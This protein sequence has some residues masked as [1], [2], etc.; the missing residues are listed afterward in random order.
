MATQALAINGAKVYIVGRTGEKPET[1][2]RTH[3]QGIAGKIIP[4]AADIT[5]KSAI[6]KL[7]KEI[8]SQEKCQFKVSN[9][10]RKLE[11]SVTG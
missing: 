6:T 11:F 4:I 7:V 5:S 3:G 9:R 1:V 2:V 10:S 8:E